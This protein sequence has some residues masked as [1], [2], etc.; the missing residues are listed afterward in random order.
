MPLLPS[1]LT[2]AK[3]KMEINRAERELE[4]FQLTGVFKRHEK[5]TNPPSKRKNGKKN[6]A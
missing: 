1:F 3:T 5:I 4:N 2:N 6:A